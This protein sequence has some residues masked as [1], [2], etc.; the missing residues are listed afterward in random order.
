MPSC[1]SKLS[2][3][4]ENEFS[5][6]LNK[7]SDYPK[8]NWHLF[9][10]AA[11]NGHLWWLTKT[12]TSQKVFWCCF[13]RNVVSAQYFYLWQICLV[14]KYCILNVVKLKKPI[15]SNVISVFKCET[16]KVKNTFHQT[17]IL[18]VLKLYNHNV[19]WLMIVY[20]LLRISSYFI[21]LNELKLLTTQTKNS[22]HLK[23][24]IICVSNGIRI[25]SVMELDE[26]VK[27][28]NSCIKN[29]PTDGKSQEENSSVLSSD[30]DKPDDHL[31]V[32]N[33]NQIMKKSDYSQVNNSVLHENSIDVKI[34]EEKQEDVKNELLPNGD[35]NLNCLN[36]CNDLD[37]KKSVDFAEVL[38]PNNKK[39]N[40]VK[41]I[42]NGNND[43]VIANAIKCE[44]KNTSNDIVKNC[45]VSLNFHLAFMFKTFQPM[46]KFSQSN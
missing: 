34:K 6:K 32:I 13:E 40:L 44:Y 39:L 38:E 42:T 23:N 2:I 24:K 22:K 28:T 36:N 16:S 8:A 9:F 14:L 43:E 17:Y 1:S 37:F 18:I 19:I 45:E 46:Y 41:D 21:L 4:R 20:F 27:E 10:G 25:N 15:N 7:L 33:D 26:T 31:T 11:P 35:L 29:L 3:P 5:I 30:D 12:V